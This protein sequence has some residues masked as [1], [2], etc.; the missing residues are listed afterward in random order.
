MSGKRISCSDHIM[1]LMRS[2]PGDTSLQK[3]IKNARKYKLEHTIPLSS[4]ALFV[5]SKET[6][7]AQRYGNCF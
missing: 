5:A 1:I 4:I 7:L 6:M 2:S 3:K